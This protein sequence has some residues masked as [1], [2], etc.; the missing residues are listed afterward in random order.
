M[1]VKPLLEAVLGL[2]PDSLTKEIRLTE[3]L[4]R[5][6]VEYQIPTDLVASGQAGA[7]AAPAAAAGARVEQV[8]ASVAAL[9]AMI[10]EAKKRELAERDS[11]RKYRAEAEKLERERA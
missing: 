1:Q 10:E 7:E 11:E 9:L 2:E 5:L 6:F 4:T 8:K 3:D